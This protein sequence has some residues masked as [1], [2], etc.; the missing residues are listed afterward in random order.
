MIIMPGGPSGSSL[1]AQN[2][3][4]EAIQIKISENATIGT[5]NV[6]ESLEY[7]IIYSDGTSIYS[8]EGTMTLTSLNSREGVAAGTFEVTATSSDGGTSFSIT[9]EAFVY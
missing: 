5:H 1:S 7:T 3:K 9:E 8:S 2:S 6:G 4:S